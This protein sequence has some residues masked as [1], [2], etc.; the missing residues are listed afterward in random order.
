MTIGCT[1]VRKPR[2]LNSCQPRPNAIATIASPSTQGGQEDNST[3]C[4]L[5]NTF[6]GYLNKNS[7]ISFVARSVCFARLVSHGIDEIVDAGAVRLRGE[8]LGIER[9]IGVFPC[10]S[11]VLIETHR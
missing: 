3:N 9:A 2:P 11:I 6:A 1:P 10:V 7:N 8:L 5:E 4:P